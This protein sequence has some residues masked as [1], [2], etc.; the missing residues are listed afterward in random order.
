[1][2]VLLIPCEKDPTPDCQQ[3]GSADDIWDRLMNCWGLTGTSLSWKL[4]VPG[5][6]SLC[7]SEYVLRFSRWPD[8]SSRR[9]TIRK[10]LTSLE[11]G[12][13][14]GREPVGRSC[15]FRIVRPSLIAASLSPGRPHHI[16]DVAVKDRF[17][18]HPTVSNFVVQKRAVTGPDWV[19]RLDWRRDC[20]RLDPPDCCIV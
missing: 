17:N 15:M 20:K 13:A 5:S 1:M 11:A 19:Y 16:R 2:L 3:A 14:T 10:I 9:P 8:A 7:T 12:L 4:P 18:L 6:R